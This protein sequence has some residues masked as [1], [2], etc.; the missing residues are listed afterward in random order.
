[1]KKIDFKSVAEKL[2]TTD[3]KKLAKDFWY[4]KPHQERRLGDLYIDK[5]GLYKHREWRGFKDTMYYFYNIW[6]YNYIHMVADVIKLGGLVNFAKKRMT[7][8][9]IQRIQTFQRVPYRFEADP[10]LQAWLESPLTIEPASFF[11]RSKKLEPTSC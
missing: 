11:E 4:G 5:T 7:A 10:A 2:K 3:Y 1:M 6:L 9:V 8:S